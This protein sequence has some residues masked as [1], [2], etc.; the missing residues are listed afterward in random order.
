M[1]AFKVKEDGKLSKIILKE[2]PDVKYSS[3]LKLLRKKYIKVNG[4]RVKTDVNITKND[5][6]ELYLNDSDLK[7]I[8]IIKV[9]ED[10]N[11]LIVD[12][13]KKITSEQLFDELKK[14]YGENIFFVHRL[15]TNT[16]GVI[17]FAKNERAYESLL[18]CFK[19]RKVKK[20]YLAEVYGIVEKENSFEVA[21]LKKDKD[22]SLVTISKDKKDGYAKIETEYKVLE[23]KENSTLLEVILHSGKTHQI[24][25]HLAFLG[26]FVLGDGKYGKEKINRELGLNSQKLVAKSLEFDFDQKNELFYLNNRKF[27]SHFTL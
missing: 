14:S 27:V 18:C 5:V 15:D 16:T 6:V 21:Y 11:I 26:H 17:S 3:I 23:K 8:E 2:Y 22:K 20:V 25:A 7:K 1:R 24:R 19:N 13:N 12:K 9:Y 10:D 4:N